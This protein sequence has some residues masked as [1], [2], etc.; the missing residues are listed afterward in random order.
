MADRDRQRGTPQRMNTEAPR[1]SGDS[2]SALELTRRDVLGAAL[3]VSTGIAIGA[4]LN[5]EPTQA[6]ALP[7]QPPVAAVSPEGGGPVPVSLQINGQ[8]HS[9]PLEPRVTLLDALREH[10]GMFGAKK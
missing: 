4:L 7:G 9:L 8:T 2:G 5:P 3:T 1:D 6:A 10:L